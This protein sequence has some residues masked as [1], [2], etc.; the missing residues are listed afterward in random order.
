[1]KTFSSDVLDRLSAGEVD[2]IDAATLILDSGIVNVW[3][4]GR[5][6][7]PWTD[8]EMG[9]QT[10]YG[11][12][13]LLSM[14]IPG[15]SLAGNSAQVILRL[16]ETYMVEGSDTPASIWDAVIDE[17]PE[18]DPD[19]EPWQGREVILSTFWRDADGSILYRETVE[20]LQIDCMEIEKDETGRPVRVITLE[21]PDVIRRDIEGKTDNAEFQ[22]LI[23]ADDKG[24]EH[25]GQTA[26]Q[27]IN[28][29]RLQDGA[30]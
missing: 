10:F 27:K 3:I 25:V 29:G 17:S 24:Y 30:A 13:V 28:W 15:N 23:D 21:R 12:G 14:D 9:S 20:R 2:F 18:F 11:F 6:E 5:G 1:M 16:N 22:K 19:L 7:F 26:T 4:G 8:S